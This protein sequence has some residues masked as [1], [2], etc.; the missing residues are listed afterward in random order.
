[1]VSKNI[2]FVRKVAINIVKDGLFELQNFC[3]SKWA[4]Q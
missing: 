2:V 4:W 3:Q 1:M